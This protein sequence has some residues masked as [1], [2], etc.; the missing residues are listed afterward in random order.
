MTNVQFTL[1]EYL[2]NNRDMFD[3]T[4]DETAAS[5]QLDSVRPDE[6]IDN[7]EDQCD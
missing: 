5:S 2:L 1:A 6:T 7:E 4:A 3:E